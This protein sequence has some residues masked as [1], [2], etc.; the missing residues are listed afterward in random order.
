MVVFVGIFVMW[1]VLRERSL[2]F[3]AEPRYAV[4]QDFLA[5]AHFLKLRDHGV[6]LDQFQ[7]MFIGRRLSLKKSEHGISHGVRYNSAGG[8]TRS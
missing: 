8:Q 3:S 6:V 5:P 2:E 1:F 7:D 4:Y